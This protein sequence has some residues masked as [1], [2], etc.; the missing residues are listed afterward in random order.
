MQDMLCY[1]ET[2][3]LRPMIVFPWGHN[4]TDFISFPRLITEYLNLP[5]T[6]RLLSIDSSFDSLNWTIASWDVNMAFDVSGDVLQSSDKYIEALLE[7]GVKVLIYAG[8][9]DMAC[10]WVGND[11]MTMALEWYGRNGFVTTKLRDWYLDIDANEKPAGKTRS[12]EGLTF[13]SVYDS[14]HMVLDSA[15]AL[16]TR[17]TCVYCRCLTIDPA[18]LGPHKPLVN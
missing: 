10:N 4:L 5:S 3:Y 2:R 14:G 15:L 11:R 16:M 6:R 1:A 8:T 7:R 12:F 9:Y 18:S 17:L 13:A